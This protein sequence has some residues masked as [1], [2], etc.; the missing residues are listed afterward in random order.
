MVTHTVTYT[1]S[2]VSFEGRSSEVGITSKITSKSLSSSPILT[3]HVNILCMLICV[4]ISYMP[5]TLISISSFFFL[6]VSRAPLWV[7]CLLN[8]SSSSCNRD[9]LSSMVFFCL[10]SDSYSACNDLMSV[11]S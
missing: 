10:C 3:K 7:A 4:Y 11:F 5:L 1:F 2:A 6:S 8:L 9:T